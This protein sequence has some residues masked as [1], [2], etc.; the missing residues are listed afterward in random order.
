MI[1]SHFGSSSCPW[2]FCLYG[3]R[4]LRGGIP[5]LGAAASIQRHLAQ[6]TTY[7]PAALSPLLFLW[8]MTLL[9]VTT[10]AGA[11]LE[12]LDQVACTAAL[13]E[14]LHVAGAPVVP[15]FLDKL[16]FSASDSGPSSAKTTFDAKF[17]DTGEPIAQPKFNVKLND[18]GV[19]TAEPIVNAKFLDPGEFKALDTVCEKLQ[20]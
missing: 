10:H 12:V 15:I 8:P 9:R 14:V 1:R 5:G 11:I 13:R 19:T 2:D 20:H 18:P 16:L 4:P 3:L 17:V 6:T 7:F